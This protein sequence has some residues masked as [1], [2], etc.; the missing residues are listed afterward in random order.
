MRTKALKKL[1]MTKPKKDKPIKAKNLL[2]TGSTLLNLAA[3]GDYRGGYVAGRY[4][5]FVGDSMS[6]KTWYSMTCLAEATQNKRFDNH[7]F[8][9]DDVEGGALMAIQQYFGSNVADRIEPP[10][11]DDDG[12]PV[13]SSTIEE[14]YFNAYDAFRAGPCIYILDSMDAL[15]T[16]QDIEKFEEQKTAHEEG[17]DA[18]G[19]YGMSKAKANSA[20]MRRLLKPMRKHGSILIVICQTRDNVGFG[21]ETRTRAGGRALRFYADLEIWSSIKGKVKR[22]IKGKKRQV[23]VECKLEI[24]KNRF[25]GQE[26]DVVVPF[27]HMYGVDDVSSCVNYLLDEGHW[28]KRKQSIVA[29][30]FDECMP[31]D[32]LVGFIEDNGLE[33]D[34]REIVGDVWREVQKACRQSRKPRYR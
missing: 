17:K 20:N 26:M 22:T 4:V 30:D 9:H 14:F 29:T 6:G 18:K 19:S 3:T 7:R 25:S 33:N 15:D 13:C 10:A 31:M 11:I 21:F 8:V 24:K 1:L 34:L 16:S 32:R 2:N 23:G 5:F 28:K 12:E 27:Q